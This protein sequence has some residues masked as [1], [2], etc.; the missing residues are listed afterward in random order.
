LI[1]NDDLFLKLIILPTFAKHPD[2]AMV[3]RPFVRFETSLKEPI[4]FR[5]FYQ[6]KVVSKRR[7][8]VDFLGLAVLLADVIN[9]AWA[10]KSTTQVTALYIIKFI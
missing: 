7:S 10:K 4:G 6:L 2:I 5:V 3:S 1:G 9:T 8:E